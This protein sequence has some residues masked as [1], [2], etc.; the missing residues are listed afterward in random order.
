MLRLCTRTYE[1]AKRRCRK[2]VFVSRSFDS[3]GTNLQPYVALWGPSI[4]SSTDSSV[5]PKEG[6]AEQSDSH[7]Y[8]SQSSFKR[9]ARRP[10][11]PV[12]T[13]I[14]SDIRSK[15][16]G[17]VHSYER[18]LD[19][20][21]APGFLRLRPVSV[22]IERFIQ[23][24][25]SVCSASSSVRRDYVKYLHLSM[26]ELDTGLHVTRVGDCLVNILPHDPA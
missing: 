5:A 8:R 13:V 1:N 6:D 7:A 4:F 2:E 26:R 20:D 9:V 21:L 19:L 11:S 23:R 10:T 22:Q 16:H 15:L 18:A 3:S 14:N 25:R 24:T 17:R 12:P